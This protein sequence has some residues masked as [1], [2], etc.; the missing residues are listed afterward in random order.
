MAMLLEEH[1]LLRASLHALEAKADSS[2]DDGYFT[3]SY[4]VAEALPPPFD[5]QAILNWDLD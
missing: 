5:L 1:R 3:V 4:E 2:F